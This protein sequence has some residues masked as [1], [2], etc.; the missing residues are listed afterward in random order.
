MERH[1]PSR[2]PLDDFVWK[3]SDLTKPLAGTGTKR[4]PAVGQRGWPIVAG[5][6]EVA[7]AGEGP[8][9]EFRG[10]GSTISLRGPAG[11]RAGRV[12]GAGGWAGPRLSLSS[13]GPR[14]A[15]SGTTRLA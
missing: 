10:L 12:C 7:R 15:S 4:R 1:D 14:D 8:S 9:A 11:P 6:G 5:P 13:A 2:Q 3:V